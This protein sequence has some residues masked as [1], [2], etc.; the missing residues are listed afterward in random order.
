MRTWVVA[1]AVFLGAW[2]TSTARAQSRVSI[3]V[4]GAIS[5]YDFGGSSTGANHAA[6]STASMVPMPTSGSVGSTSVAGAT[7]GQPRDVGNGIGVFEVRPTIILERG[8]LFAVGFRDGTAGFGHGSTNLVG[9]D[10]SIGYAH[11]WGRFLPFIKGMFGFNNYDSLDG[12]Q[13]QPKRTDLRLDAVVGTRLYVS[14]RLFVSASAFGGMGDQF[15]GSIAVGGDVVQI[16]HRGW[17]P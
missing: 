11:R 6:L 10:V 8:L 16:F 13:M 4:G 17:L 9:G 12:N 3:E 1:S 2:W 14:Q 5:S 7:A 15:G